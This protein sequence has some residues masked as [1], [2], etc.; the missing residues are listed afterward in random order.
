MNIEEVIHASSLV[1]YG[2]SV[3][4]S[5]KNRDE[6]VNVDSEIGQSTPVWGTTR[7]S[8]PAREELASKPTRPPAPLHAMISPTD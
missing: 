2:G 4:T 3:G 7:I 6:D 8:G 1:M 5:V